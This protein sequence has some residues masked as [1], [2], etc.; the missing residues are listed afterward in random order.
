MLLYR[1]HKDAW[2]DHLQKSITIASLSKQLSTPL[3]TPNLKK[4]IPLS[5]LA[6]TKTSE[7]SDSDIGLKRR[8]KYFLQQQKK[9]KLKRHDEDT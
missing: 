3:P 2:E 1:L 4:V 9:R 5:N 8:K 6:I 7:T